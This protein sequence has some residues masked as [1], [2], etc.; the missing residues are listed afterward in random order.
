MTLLSKLNLKAIKKRKNKVFALFVLVCGVVLSVYYILFHSFFFDIEEVE[1]STD[2]SEIGIV[3]LHNILNEKVIH[4]NI[5]QVR[6]SYI[7]KVVNEEAP[8]FKVISLARLLP[9]KIFLKLKERKN[10]YLVRAKNGYFVLD[11]VGFIIESG[12]SGEEKKIDIDYDMILN[13]GVSA[14]S[15]LKVA[16]LYAG[17]GQRVIVR[18]GEIMLRLDNGGTVLLPSMSDGESIF[19]TLSVLKKI[20]QKY[21][22]EDRELELIDLR[23]SKPVIKFK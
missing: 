6:F 19:K 21:T 7:E 2:V 16:M 23:Y 22:I 9:N 20:I 5:F 13:R 1:L 18:D 3:R 14:N 17:S 4:K 10:K 12:I 15:V 11:G 8:Q